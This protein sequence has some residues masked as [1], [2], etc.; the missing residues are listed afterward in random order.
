MPSVQWNRSS[1]LLGKQ[2][3]D[4]EV[5]PLGLVRTS[6]T[7]LLTVPLVFQPRFFLRN[8]ILFHTSGTSFSAG[9]ESRPSS[10]PCGGLVG[11]MACTV[12]S[13]RNSF[14]AG[15]ESKGSNY[16]KLSLHT[17]CSPTKLECKLTSRNY[18][19]YK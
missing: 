11:L 2:N 12:S 10:M 3:G 4:N 5:R 19:G 15:A 1:L 14:S 7:I 17:Y 16:L 8:T 9:A 13:V 6:C 18:V